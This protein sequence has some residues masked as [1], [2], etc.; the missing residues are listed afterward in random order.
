M[1][2]FAQFFQPLVFFATEIGRLPQSAQLR[3][4]TVLLR[5]TRRQRKKTHFSFLESHASF[6]LPTPFYEYVQSTYLAHG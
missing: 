5:V 2:N 3:Q 6:G 1:F 4:R